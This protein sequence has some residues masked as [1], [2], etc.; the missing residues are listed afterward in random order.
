MSHRVRRECGLAIF[1]C[2][3]KDLL[4]SER[5]RAF[6]DRIGW[7]ERHGEYSRWKATVLYPDPREVLDKGTVFLGPAVLKVGVYIHYQI[8]TD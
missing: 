2:R 3:K 5:R 4:T 6:R 8:R 7:T 1:D